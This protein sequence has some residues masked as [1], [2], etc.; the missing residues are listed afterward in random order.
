LQVF[1]YFV[2]EL[3]NMNDRTRSSIEA[4]TNQVL[5]VCNS[6]IV[7]ELLCTKS[8]VSPAVLDQ[9]KSIFVDF[10]VSRHGASGAFVNAVWK[11][12]VQKYI[13][14]RHANSNSKIIMIWCDEY[15]NHVNS[16]DS[17]FLAECRSHLGG[18]ICLT[19]SLHAFYSAMKGG[20][21]GEHMADSLLT[22]FGTKIF[23]A[24]GD[25][26]TANYGSTLAGRTLRTFV[27]G[28]ENQRMSVGDA[29]FGNPVF[30][31]SFN[32]HFEQVLQ[33]RQFMTGLRTGGPPDYVVDGFVLRAGM[34]FSNGEPYLKVAFS[35]R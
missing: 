5:F 17:V 16:F 12:L 22:N 24:V 14:R 35:Q 3:P 20:H 9:G 34:P 8:N 28:S 32:Q 6:G 23:C 21:T 31:G 26:R 15:Q 33:N 13:L 19:Q 10:S 4:G 25:D 27:G 29:L 18:L 11:L 2:H 30:S 1:N 7:R